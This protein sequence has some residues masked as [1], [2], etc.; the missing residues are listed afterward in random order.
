M[1]FVRGLRSGRGW[2][3]PMTAVLALF[4]VHAVVPFGGAS[5]DDGSLAG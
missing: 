5:I 3:V 4:T 1:S 2:L